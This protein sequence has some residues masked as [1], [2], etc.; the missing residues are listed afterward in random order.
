MTRDFLI[1][2]TEAQAR[3]LEA[4]CAARPGVTPE[5]LIEAWVADKLDLIQ[6]DQPK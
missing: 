1:T 2:L 3:A 4:V 5:T 6:A